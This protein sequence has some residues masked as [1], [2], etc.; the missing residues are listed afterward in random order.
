LFDVQ[1]PAAM[2]GRRQACAFVVRFHP[3]NAGL[4]CI[5]GVAGL[6]DFPH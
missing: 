4:A 6:R 5:C 1:C 3:E 2:A